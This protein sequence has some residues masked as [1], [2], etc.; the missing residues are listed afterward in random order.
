MADIKPNN[1]QETTSV[2]V[3]LDSSSI[4]SGAASVFESEDAFVESHDEA[5]QAEAI[6]S[7]EGQE[8]DSVQSQTNEE[9]ATEPQPKKSRASMPS[10]DEIVFGTKADD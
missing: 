5:P 7:P 3:A 8:F 1:A 9:V 2:F 10:W 6:D 4:V